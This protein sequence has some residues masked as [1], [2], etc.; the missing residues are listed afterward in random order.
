MKEESRQP[1]RTNIGTVS[2]ETRKYTKYF[3]FFPVYL[4]LFYLIERFPI[5]QGFHVMHCAIDDAIP[6]CEYFV[7]PYYMWHV[8]ILFFAVYTFRR[9]SEHFEKLLRFFIACCIVIFPIYILFPSCQE[10]RP[11]VMENT[12][13]FTQ[14]VQWTYSIDTNTN[15]CP[16]MH[17]MGCIGLLFTCW[18]MKGI[19]DRKGH[20]FQ[21]VLLSLICLSTMFIKQHSFIDVA[22]A[23][24]AALLGWWIG[25]GGAGRYLAGKFTEIKHRLRQRGHARRAPNIR[26]TML[27]GI[28]V[29]MWIALVLAVFINRDKLTAEGIAGIAPDDL[30]LAALAMFAAFAL[31]SLTMVFSSSVLFAASAIIFPLPMAFCVNFLGMLIIETIPYVIGRKGGPRELDRIC[32]RYPKMH[33]LRDAKIE[34]E[35]VFVMMLRINIT[36]NY[37]ICSIY[38]GARKLNSLHYYIG[39][40]IGMMPLTILNTL[41]GAGI[42]QG[43]LGLSSIL[44]VIMGVL[45]A[46]SF[47][48]FGRRIAANERNKEVK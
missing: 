29:L 48:F 46:I 36:L 24:P 25:C 45:M 11:D 18:D 7:V 47:W 5:M 10:L 20:V 39:S 32:E 13:I 17:V 37:D 3:W 31:K 6:F 43:D 1:M 23:I 33:M 8:S 27:F 42:E 2:G 16:S 28:G 22:A 41:L 19:N 44:V 12:N 14:L 21:V 15:V 38:L 4:L 9:D 35:I 34:N 26:N 30:F 40:L